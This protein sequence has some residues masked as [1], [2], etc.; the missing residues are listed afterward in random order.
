MYSSIIT[1]RHAAS[2]SP[3]LSPGVH[4]MRHP[5]R[6]DLAIYKDTTTGAVYVLAHRGRHGVTLRDL[7]SEPGDPDGVIVISEWDLWQAVQAGRW[8]RCI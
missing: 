8:Q 5:S 4:F 3:P 6:M 1:G 7:D 2:F